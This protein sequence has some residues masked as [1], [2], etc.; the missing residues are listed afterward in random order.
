MM[1][2]PLR[3]SLVI[4]ALLCATAIVGAHS[5]PPY[6]ILSNRIVGAYDLSIWSDPDSTDDGT[7]AGQFWV[8]IDPAKR[9]VE[10]PDGTRATVTIR[11]LDREGAAL[12]GAARSDGSISRQFIAL[13]MDHEGKFGVHLAVDGPL[14]HAE[15]EATVDATYDE[16]PAPYLIAVYLFPFLALGALWIKVFLRRRRRSEPDRP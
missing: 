12:S 16:R 3:A 13:L 9:G 15:V 7:P 4:A 5:G 2:L 1:R 14:G 8:V 11:P 10:I 6:P